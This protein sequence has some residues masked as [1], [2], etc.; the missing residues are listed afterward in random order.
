MHGE[1]KTSKDY[2]NV[3]RAFMQG[4]YEPTIA[5]AFENVDIELEYGGGSKVLEDYEDFKSF[6]M[7]LSGDI[8]DQYTNVSSCYTVNEPVSPEGAL[9]VRVTDK[10]DGGVRAEFFVLPDGRVMTEKRETYFTT[11]L[12]NQKL[13]LRAKTRVVFI[14]EDTYPFDELTAFMGQA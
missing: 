10:E 7:L 4:D 13:T 3:F 2:F 5:E 9:K 1:R 8:L 12:G 11:Y 6:V 14:T